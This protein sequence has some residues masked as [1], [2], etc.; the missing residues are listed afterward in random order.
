MSVDLLVIGLGY[1][2]LPLAR[3]ATLSGLTVVGLD[4]NEEVIAGLN[5]GRSHIGDISDR[6]IGRMLAYGFK[7]RSTA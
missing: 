5:T 7:P 6:D 2:G 1:V 3:E 4:L